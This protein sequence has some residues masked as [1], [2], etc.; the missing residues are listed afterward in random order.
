MNFGSPFKSPIQVKLTSN[1]LQKNTGK[2]SSLGLTSIADVSSPGTACAMTIK[3]HIPTVKNKLYSGH[4]LLLLS[5]L[6][7]YL[8][9]WIQIKMSIT[10]RVKCNFII[11]SYGQQKRIICRR[12]RGFVHLHCPYGLSETTGSKQCQRIDRQI[13]CYGM[14]V[15]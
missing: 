2:I 13:I 12:T 9:M 10:E 14:A 7:Q 4:K 5:S 8:R 1:I 15:K 6:P 3:L 11:L